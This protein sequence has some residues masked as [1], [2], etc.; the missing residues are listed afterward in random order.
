MVFFDVLLDV[1]H[2]SI[3]EVGEVAGASFELGGGGSE[4]GTGSG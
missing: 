1:R 2:V 3:I 4:E